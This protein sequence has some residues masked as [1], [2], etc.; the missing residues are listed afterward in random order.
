MTRKA[1]IERAQGKPV[2]AF[3]RTWPSVGQALTE[4]GI[5]S[6]TYQF[7]LKTGMSVE[8]ALSTPIGPTSKKQFT[9]EGESWRSRNRAC[10]ELAARY[11]ITPDKVRDRLVRG[12]PLTRWK[13]MDSRR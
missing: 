7:R 10:I 8:E 9:F 11:G 5:G 1:I 4:Y 3:G 6:G 2:E 13:E 12:I